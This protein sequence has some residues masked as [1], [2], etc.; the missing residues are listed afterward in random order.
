MLI[1]SVMITNIAAT[2]TIEV[3]FVLWVLEGSLYRQ[4]VVVVDWLVLD[5]YRF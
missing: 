5:T 2:I 4:I 3:H 1:F